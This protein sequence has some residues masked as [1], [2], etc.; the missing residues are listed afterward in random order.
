[1][2]EE[3]ESQKTEDATPRKLAKAREEGQVPQSQE[4]KSWMILL[5][6][7]GLLVFWAPTMAKDITVIGQ[8]LIVSSSEIHADFGSFHH[9]FM[10]VIKNLGILLAPVF[11][12]F[13][14]LALAA[15]VGQFGLLASIK[16]IQPKPNKINPLTGFKRI[17]SSQGLAEFF[18]GIL[19]IC[20]V[21][22]VSFGLA[23]PMLSDLEIMPALST[24]AALARMHDLMIMMAFATVAVMAVIAALDYIYQRTNFMKQMRMSKTEVKDEN[25]QAE[26]DPQVKARIRQIRAQRARQRMMAAVPMADVVVTNPTHFAVALEYKM[27]TM[28]APKV[29]AKGQ[30]FVALKIREIAE[31]NEVP[32][33]EN[34]PLARAL[35]ASVELDQEIPPE[36]FKAVAEV[37]GYVMRLK[38][39]L[40]SAPPE[41]DPPVLR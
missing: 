24:G 11:G 31:A 4:I 6:G 32:I 20:A 3:D 29:V 30:D 13:V 18:K 23:I 22:L 36:H 27:D 40:P 9:L 34:P 10:N 17:F 41:R 7:A 37:I 5:G 14:V 12:L 8:Q 16:K 15:N 39:T 38:G 1:M 2:S 28:P 33:V 35:F 21:S 25:K 26:G 19:K